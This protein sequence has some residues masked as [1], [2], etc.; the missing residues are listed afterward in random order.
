VRVI[1]AGRDIPPGA[2][3]GPV[4]VIPRDPAAPPRDPRKVLRLLIEVA[5]DAVPTYFSNPAKVTITKE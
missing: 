1:L 4:A 5:P 2:A 3:V